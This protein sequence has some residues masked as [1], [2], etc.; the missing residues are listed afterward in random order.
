MREID[1]AGLRFGRLV[2]VRKVASGKW[3]CRCDCGTIT[4]ATSG[5]LRAGRTRSCGCL[6]GET[7]RIVQSEDGPRSTGKRRVHGHSPWRRKRSATYRS[8]TAIKT[9]C[10]NPNA[11]DYA[12]YGGSGITLCERWRKFENFLADMG[13][14]PGPGYNVHRK[15]SKRGYEPGNCEWLSKGAHSTLHNKDRAA[16]GGYAD[17]ARDPN[18][19]RF[20]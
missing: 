4:L 11:T 20:A 15:D 10:L 16:R 3:E 6:R 14:A 19:G 18:T 8:W 9:R 1:I 7:A 2:A 5:N 17:V 12:R 13:E